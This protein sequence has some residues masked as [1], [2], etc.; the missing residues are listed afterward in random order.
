LHHSL[1]GIANPYINN[2]HTSG[3]FGMLIA[4]APAPS[5][6]AGEGGV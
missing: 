3:S 4:I 1:Y 2:L 6:R 5:W